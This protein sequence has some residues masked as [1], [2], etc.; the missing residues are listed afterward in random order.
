MVIIV[1]HD[2]H[3]KVEGCLPKHDSWGFV[4]CLTQ[5]GGA[6]MCNG[7]TV[8][9]VATWHVMAGGVNAPLVW[10]FGF[11][12]SFQFFCVWFLNFLSLLFFLH[13][14]FSLSIVALCLS[15]FK[16]FS[17]TISCVLPSC[18]CLFRM[19]SSFLPF[20]SS[21]HRQ[22]VKKF[23]F[24]S[25]FEFLGFCPPFSFSGFHGW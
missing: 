8:H 17:P 19:Y 6:L 15:F 21:W 22:F 24:H 9:I 2:D 4:P 1:C 14:F 7:G 13:F 3:Q 5:S 18:E 16:L 10:L 20:Y 12:A 25:C 11:L 23:Y